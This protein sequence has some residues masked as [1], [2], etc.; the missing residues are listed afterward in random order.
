MIAEL[1]SM[2]STVD[3]SSKDGKTRLNVNLNRNRIRSIS[4]FSSNSIFYFKTIVSDQ[5]T[6]EEVAMISRMLEKSYASFVVACIGLMPFHRVKADDQAA[7]ESYL[8]QFHQN[9]G[10]SDGSDIVMSKVFALAD[11]I[12]ESVS[13]ADLAVARDFLMEC[14][15]KSRKN[16]SRYV[17]LVAD[18]LR[19]VN[20]MYSVDPIDPVTRVFQESYLKRLDELDTWGF[21]GEATANLLDNFDEIESM[22]DA[23]IIQSM[24]S[25]DEDIDDDDGLEYDYVDLD[26]Y[27]GENGTLT[28]SQ[29]DELTA[30]LNQAPY[31]G[32]P[33]FDFDFS[34][35]EAPSGPASG[36]GAAADA[37]SSIAGV[38]K[39]A[40]TAA[41]VIGNVAAGAAGAWFGY[42]IGKLV[43]KIRDSSDIKKLKNEIDRIKAE[44]NVLGRSLYEAAG[45]AGVI[46][47]GA[48]VVGGVVGY[49]K[50]RKEND[51]EI[52]ELHQRLL[53]LELT[54]LQL[55]DGY[56]SR[57]K[58]L[59]KDITKEPMLLGDKLLADH[60][61]RGWK[62]PIRRKSKN[63]S[64]SL[65]EGNV[66]GA[67]NSIIFSLESVS[68]N[69]IKSC[70]S[71]TKLT[72]LEAK[73]NKMKNKYAKYLNRYKKKYKENKEKKTKSKLTIRFNGETIS[74]P[75]AFMK[76]Y[77][78]YIKIINKRLKMVEKRREELRKRK[79]L[80]AGDTAKLEE[81]AI[82]V[83]SDLDLQVIDHCLESID[84]QL[85]A[86]DS[87][88]FSEVLDEATGAQMAAVYED[89]EA[90]INNL[91]NALE[92]QGKLT[93]E[94]E[95]AKKELAREAAKL[96]ARYIAAKGKEDELARIIADQQKT[97]DS[98]QK[99][100]D[101]AGV[102]VDPDFEI[103]DV[104]MN[105]DWHKSRPANGV[106][107]GKM[108]ANGQTEIKTF[109]DK[110]FTD[111]D[112][113]KANEAIP[114]FA[115]ATIGFVIDETEQVV[116][117]DILV[118]VKVHIH[119]VPAMDL[120]NDIYNCIINKRQFLKF[121]KWISGEEK[122]LS[123][124]LF[125]FK[126]LRTDALNSRNG[127]A[128]QWGAAF[129]RRKRWKDMSVPYLMKSY[130]PNGTVVLTM[131][132]VQFIK[133][134]YG[135]DVM[136]PDHVQM[137]MESSFLLGF[138]ILDQANE[139]V[140]V[141]YDGDSG[142][143]QQYTY[144]MLE[145]DQATSDRAMRELYRSFAR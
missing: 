14:W 86:P 4:A 114:T 25:D 43:A 94:T 47:V 42:N 10:I 80:P 107:L 135:L 92:K 19:S 87:E 65:T 8:K 134:E 103:G 137:L 17:E 111:M 73:L 117:R 118:G 27:L 29:Y 57:K 64:A 89:L 95:A 138:V 125:G 31:D 123:D 108:A 98:L 143:L 79:G 72:Q 67:V 59:P 63:E 41:R 23:D 75:K 110:I 126:E 44:N 97:L 141:S 16:C 119:K 82:G 85:N 61:A 96:Q 5:A 100:A 39:A 50:K 83:L 26:R 93:R 124:L 133:D 45:A 22:E 51:A 38:S 68:E 78:G 139:M 28:E 84:R 46:A 32:P 37:M 81:N 136:R 53:E 127:K 56:K 109:N 34:G 102:K 112:M 21:I 36:G 122:S 20:E 60:N 91:A 52:A 6:P 12:S 2:L 24:F 40:Q 115:R 13:E 49:N 116:N 18:H 101:A 106:N 132:E 70:S 1:F 105:V 88:I 77:G 3:V 62:F 66:K 131:N 90:R 120:I 113:K 130:T 71:L 104:G 7:I 140:Y 129:R 69:K 58:P 30:I 145:R 11:T 121:V 9:L 99:Q 33:A 76:Q 55:R 142:N 144:A 48:G 74:N 15:D 54:N 35:L 128:G